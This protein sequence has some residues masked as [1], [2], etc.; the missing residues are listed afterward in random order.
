[1]E[2]RTDLAGSNLEEKS[3][4]YISIADGYY[5]EYAE[6]KEGDDIKQIV[7]EYLSD[8]EFNDAEEPADISVVIYRDG[9]DDEQ[10]ACRLMPDHELE[11]WK[12]VA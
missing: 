7:T 9:N 10:Y 1:M 6:Y 5:G 11:D 8:Y 4:T 12:L 2:E 3:G